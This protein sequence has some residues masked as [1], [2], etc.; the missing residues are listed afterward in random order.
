MNQEHGFDR[1]YKGSGI[2]RFA[3]TSLTLVANPLRNK[4]LDCKLLMRKGL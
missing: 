4:A 1:K 2:T 3:H